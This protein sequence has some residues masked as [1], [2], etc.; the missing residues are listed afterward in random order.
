MKITHTSPNKITSINKNGQFDDCLFFSADEYSMTTKGD[1]YVYSIELL[2]SKIIEVSELYNEEVIANIASV[3]DVD[4]DAAERLLDGRDTAFD[5]DLDGEDDWW[6][7]AKQGECAKLM[8]Y[9]AVES[10]DEQGTVY[11]VPM[12]NRENDLVLERVD[13]A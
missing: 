6:I 12:A 1:L 2:D 5:H 8:G 10:Q 11:I 4:E 7:Q 9:E 3:L 13:A